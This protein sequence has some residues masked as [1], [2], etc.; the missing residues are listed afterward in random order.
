MNHEDLAPPY[1][2]HEFAFVQGTDPALVA[3]NH[4]AAGKAWIDTSAGNTLKVRNPAN[5]GWLTIFAGSSQVGAN[6]TLVPGLITITIDALPAPIGGA[7]SLINY[8]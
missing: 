3:A 2:V 6:F 4:V 5:S 1:A 8:V 7:F